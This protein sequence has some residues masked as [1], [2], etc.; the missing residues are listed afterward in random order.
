MG[1]KE[2]KK[3]QKLRERIAMKMVH[4]GDKFDETRDDEMFDLK[5]ISMGAKG[6]KQVVGDEKDDDKRGDA[7]VEMPEVEDDDDSEED[8]PL[9]MKKKLV[10]FKKNDDEDDDDDDDDDNDGKTSLIEKKNLGYM[11]DKIANETIDSDEEDS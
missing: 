6:L 3:K 9:P 2:A 4:V 10:S 8:E 1:K 5:R 7:R 11:G